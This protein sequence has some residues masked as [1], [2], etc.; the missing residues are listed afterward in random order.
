MD[1]DY[2]ILKSEQLDVDDIKESMHELSE[3]ASVQSSKIEELQKK[4]DQIYKSQGL[5]KPEIK[6]KKQEAITTITNKYEAMSYQELADEAYQDLTD[7]GLDPENIKREDLLDSEIIEEIDKELNRPVARAEK[8]GT[9]DFIIVFSAAIVGITADFVL[10]NRDNPLTGQN[11]E[12][13]KY[14]DEL[15]KHKP[16]S[17]IDYQGKY[18]GA[19]KES[20]ANLG[21]HRILAKGHDLFRIIEAIWQIKNGT[22]VGITHHNGIAEKIVSNVNQYGKPYEVCETYYEALKFFIE[23]MKG[24]FFSK[25]SLPIPG[26]SFFMESDSR[27]LRLLTVN[28]YKQGLN[29]KNVAIQSVSTIGIELIL[30]VYMGIVA[31]QELIETSDIY[32]ENDFSNADKIKMILFPARNAKNREMF[33]LAHTVVMATN[34]GKIIITKRPQDINLTEILAVIRYLIPYLNEVRK[35]HSKVAKLK[36]NTNEILEEWERLEAEICPEEIVKALPNRPF[37]V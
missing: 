9:N 8:W 30:R 17:P 22:F 11:S 7:H 36:R 15:H 32:V 20:G 2:I 10:G 27:A 16:N 12:F 18:F 37:T 33:L 19:D 13:S 28:L 29:M 21:T 31:T 25:M 5:E 23:H 4:L 3:I 26:Y 14:L 1:K 24:D 35:R 34:T 6:Y